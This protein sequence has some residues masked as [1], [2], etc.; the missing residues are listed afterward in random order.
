MK[1]DLHFIFATSCNRFLEFWLAEVQ[2]RN[3]ALPFVETAEDP[4]ETYEW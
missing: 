4:Q 3:E 2:M 1:S